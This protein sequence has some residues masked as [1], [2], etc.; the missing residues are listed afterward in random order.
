MVVNAQFVVEHYLKMEIEYITKKNLSKKDTIQFYLD[1][2]NNIYDAIDKTCQYHG[3]S[4]EQST[5]RNT[6]AFNYLEVIISILNDGWYPNWDDSNEEKWC[7]YL[8]VED[9]I[10]YW[11]VSSYYS[12]T[13]C[14]SIFFI[15]SE[16]L[17]LYLKDIALELYKDLYV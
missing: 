2:G 14:P 17:C 12:A 8:K 16:E 13:C 9:C 1:L 11:L 5:K 4:I 7:V 3:I 15:K 10:L 6:R